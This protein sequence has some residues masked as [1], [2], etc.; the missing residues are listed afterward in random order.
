MNRLNRIRKYTD[1]ITHLYY[2]I[3]IATMFNFDYLPFLISKQT[4]YQRRL[5]LLRVKEYLNR[6]DLKR[7]ISP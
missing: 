4:Y 5:T 7:F 1:I 6:M 3:S 2:D